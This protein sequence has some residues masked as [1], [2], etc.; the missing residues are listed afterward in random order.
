M[1]NLPVLPDLVRFRIERLADWLAVGVAVSLPWSTSATGIFIALWFVAS[2][3]VLDFSLVRRELTSAPGGL[4]VLLW[5]LAA[6]G[7]LWADVTWGERIA[8][9]GGF[10]R[11]LCIPLL[12]A[13]FRHSARGD[14]VVYGYFASVLGILLLSWGMVIIPNLPWQ[15]KMPGVPIKDYIFQS[16]EFLICA[17]V[18]LGSAFDDCRAQKWRALLCSVVAAL[19]LA[20]II[21]V[22]TG[23]TALLVIPVLV[24]LLGWRV[25]RWKGLLGAV[26]LG[27]V[28]G[29]VIWQA[30]PYLRER[31][32]DS[33]SDL[34]AYNNNGAWSSTAVHLEFL[35]K[36]MRFITTAPIIGHGTGSIAEQFRNAVVG[37]SGAASVTSNNPHDQIFAVAIQLGLIGASILLAMW[38]AHFMLFRAVGLTAWIGTIIVVESVVSSLVNSNLFNF[39]E[40][41]LYVFG[42]GV[43]GG[44]VLR[45]RDFALSGRIASKP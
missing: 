10:N 35:K 21:F 29:M 40:G 17:F 38:I 39:S 22:V 9:L 23:R 28:V 26:L 20:N 8:G 12:I 5:L 43:M 45:S 4:P 32:H 2:L 16:T 18:L 31:L 19:F 11:L 24:L 1:K 27:C 13:Q 33:I 41:W 36:S 25:F 14:W 34:Q 6:L 42:V 3:A 15:G 44:M 30:S 37:E 7:T